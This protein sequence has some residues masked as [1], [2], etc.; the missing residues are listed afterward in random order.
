MISILIV[1]T[2][3]FVVF[4]LFDM[5]SDLRDNSKHYRGVLDSVISEREAAKDRI[6]QK[7]NTFVLIVV[8]FIAALAYINHLLF[9]T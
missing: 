7:V 8:S 2:I 6:K 9:G 1:L 5:A 4:R 3:L